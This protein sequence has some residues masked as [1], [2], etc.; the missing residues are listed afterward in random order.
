[1]GLFSLED[2]ADGLNGAGS[3]WA[4]GDFNHDGVVDIPNDFP[5]MLRGFFGEGATAAMVDDYIQ[6]VESSHQLSAS[7]AAQLFALVP[8]PDLAVAILPAVIWLLSRRA[9]REI[10]NYRRLR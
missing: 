3:T 10:F 6:D 8:E 7:Q 2:Y 5:L 1:V 4:N 9:C